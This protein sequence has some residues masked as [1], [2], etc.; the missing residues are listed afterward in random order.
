MR[1]LSALGYRQVLAWA[2]IGLA[3]SALGSSVTQALSA[4]SGANDR[5]VLADELAD[6]RAQN[7]DLERQLD[8]R[9]VLSADVDRIQADVFVTTALALAA[10]GRGQTGVVDLYVARLDQLAIELDRAA[11][12]RQDAVQVCDTEP[13]NVLG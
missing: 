2:T 4:R 12:L 9:Y 1:R 7:D 13:E 10:A 6:R 8:C 11:D 3:V 5:A